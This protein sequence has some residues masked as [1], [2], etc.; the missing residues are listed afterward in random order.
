MKPKPVVKKNQTKPKAPP[1]KP[2]EP[3]KPK[4]V[5]EQ[6]EEA[7]GQGKSLAEIQRTIQEQKPYYIEAKK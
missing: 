4:P 3:P 6:V 7:L 1:P 2:V 5:N